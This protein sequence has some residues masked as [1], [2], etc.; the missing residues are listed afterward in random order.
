MLQMR[1]SILLY[2]EKTLQKLDKINTKI[3]DLFQSEIDLENQHV[4]QISEI[5]I[6]FTAQKE[7]LSSQFKALYKLAEQT[8]KTFLNAVAAQEQKQ[9]NGLDKL[10]K[11]LLKA[12]RRKLKNELDRLITIQNK[13]FPNGKLQERYVNFSDLYLSFGEEFFE[14]L[15][16]NLQ[17]FDF[18]FSL[19]KM[20]SSPKS[21][22]EVYT[23][24]QI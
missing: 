2:S 23:T 1:N 13:L 20:E 21:L 5:G 15:F 3:E 22:K 10:E 7:H 6:D 14:V 12:Q 16:E 11:R 18:S 4:K 9:H 19:I 17:P 8:D 24:K